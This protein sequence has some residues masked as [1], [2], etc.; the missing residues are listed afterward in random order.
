VQNLG[1]GAV[2]VPVWAV[3]KTITTN[4]LSGT[5]AVIRQSQY[6]YTGPV[7]DAVNDLFLGFESVTETRSGDVSGSPGTI[8]ATYFATTAEPLSGSQRQVSESY[9]SRGL[10]G[11]V[12]LSD[13][14]GARF[15][16]TAYQY[17]EQSY[18][19][20][21]G[22]FGTVLQTLQTDTYLWGDSQ[23]GQPFAGPPAVDA[24]F[25][26]S[27]HPLIPSPAVD[28][29]TVR[30][31]DANGNETVDTDYGLVGSDQTIVHTRIWGLSPGDKSGW[32][33]RVMHDVTGYNNGKTVREYDYTYDALGRFLT[34]SAPVSGEVQLPG[35]QPSWWNPWWFP[36]PFNPVAAGQPP[37]AL[38]HG[39][40]ALLQQVAY[41]PVYG[42]VTSSGNG[43]SPCLR[44]FVYEGVF[45]QLPQSIT[46]HPDGSCTNGGLTT[47]LTFDRRLGLVI[48]SMDPAGSL[49]T[50]GYDDFGRV[51]EIDQPSILT[52][53]ATTAVLYA[54]YADTSPIH[55]IHL[56]TGFGLDT[57]S[58][59]APTFVDHYRY[60]DGLGETRAQLDEVDPSHHVNNGSWVLSGVH[61]SYANGRTHAAF[62]P[63]FASGPS[64]PGSLPPETSAPSSPSASFVYDGLGRV[65]QA[66]DYNG[67]LSKTTYHE[68]ALSTVYQDAEQL[69]GSHPN[70]MTT[71]TRDG[72]G[73]VVT[74]DAHLN[75]GP[76]GSSGDLITTTT[77]QATGEPLSISQTYPGGSV[78][79]SMQYDS[80]GY[81]VVNA[82]PNA[83]TWQY[84]YDLAGRVVGTADARG[85]G[86]NVFYDVIGRVV[87][88]DYSP[89]TS[90][91]VAYT[92]VT[93]TPG[94]FPSPGAEVSYGYDALGRLSAVQDRGRADAYSYNAAGY[95]AQVVRQPSLP[96]T[97]VTYGA[98]HTKYFDQYSVSG[99]VMRWGIEHVALATPASG[100]VTEATAYTYEGNV[101]SVSASPT[102]AIV[103]N[104]IF[105]PDGSVATTSYG[106]A[107]GTTAVSS[108]DSNGAL[109]T[110][111]LVRSTG[112]WVNNYGAPPPGDPSLIGDLTDLVI[113]R[114]MVGNP[115]AVA[116]TSTAAWP[117]GAAAISEQL[118]YWDDYRL[119]TV[120][121]SPTDG[122]YN[123]YAYELASGSVLYPQ[124]TSPATHERLKNLALTYDWRGTV[125]TSTDDAD[126]FFDRSL[127]TVTRV[128]GTDQIAS[129]AAGNESLTP[130]YDQA[131]NLT[132]VTV[133]TSGLTTEYAYTWDE[134]GNLSSATR[135]DQLAG[136]YFHVEPTVVPETYTYASDGS[137]VRSERPA[138]FFNPLHLADPTYT[139]N[140]FDGLVL[141]DTTVTGDYEDSTSTEQLYFAQGQARVFADTT[142]TMPVV[143]N[144]KYGSPAVHTF[145]N[146]RD[147]RG[148]AAFVVDQDTGELV[149][150]TAYLAY[151]AL[152]CDYRSTRWS[153]PREDYKFGGHWDDSQVGLVYF[154]ARYY[155]P[156]LGRFISPDPL[157][158]HTLS[159]DPNPYEYG[160]GNPQLYIDPSGLDDESTDSLDYPSAAGASA[161]DSEDGQSASDAPSA[162]PFEVDPQRIGATAEQAEAER[163]QA[164]IE[165]WQTDNQLRQDAAYQAAWRAGHQA[166]PP[167]PSL[168]AGL[169]AWAEWLRSY[170]FAAT[171][172]SIWNLSG[173]PGPEYPDQTLGIIPVLAPQIQ[174]TFIGQVSGPSIVVPQGTIG[175]L[176]TDNLKGVQYSGGAG[177]PG[178]NG[179]VSGLRIMD[180][181]P[182]RPPSPGYPAGNATYFNASGQAVNPFTGRVLERADPWWHIDLRW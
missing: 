95:L 46:G 49:T 23:T 42:N 160:N 178:L 20:L 4:G 40:T 82:E 102:G 141:K 88:E 120:S 59:V 65:T 22:R 125:A 75:S 1:I 116:D 5:Q 27:G 126:D 123:P 91:Q 68:A 44:T 83:G 56:R 148:S 114:D 105:N 67:A 138:R 13:S 155:S 63:I 3:T 115:S 69:S 149:E 74:T 113:S 109:Q 9:V 55:S 89:C 134:V 128:P 111:S 168:G 176:P 100:S 87:A 182:P 118:S 31:F 45:N 36:F 60:L 163:Q 34:L 181:T 66:A 153:S 139:V 53:G 117:N 32:N 150:R 127:G 50:T 104:Q 77:Y 174:V 99:Q 158:V 41:D 57:G 11:L 164:W 85:C 154:G 39:S 101:A 142:G 175:P 16:T 43:S 64:T 6:A 10:P 146:M 78:V 106:D 157:S 151:G 86:K 124:P 156:Q 24:T 171:H 14:Y 81:L 7:Y 136:G 133:R 159:G 94:V 93:V 2:P 76:S 169:G 26:I 135:Y 62:R 61:T 162:T 152:D 122:F 72:H 80:R 161:N 79:R 30:Q 73:R 18:Y 140:V 84:A 38:T 29:R 166:E 145:I 143:A 112:P 108:Y 131:G 170:S 70:S 173:G 25:G 35:R 52:P 110:Y 71:V 147:S 103:Q 21:D 177:G 15:T 51:K 33:Y 132:H 167:Q 165:A 37:Q 12:E 137:R 180:P 107:A 90:S 179:R 96:G 54:D 172:N 17:G 119:H 129:A 8:T 47:S 48:G 98:E 58:Q 144:G 130:T 19:A 97:S 92:P 121:T 28:L